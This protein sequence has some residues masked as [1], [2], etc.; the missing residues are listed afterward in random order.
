LPFPFSFVFLKENKGTKDSRCLMKRW[1]VE[2][3]LDF[4]MGFINFFFLFLFNVGGKK[5]MKPIKIQVSFGRHQSFTVSPG[6]WLSI[7][8]AVRPT[9][10]LPGRNVKDSRRPPL[11]FFRCFP[12]GS[13]SS[14]D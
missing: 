5:K 2:K 4:S 9:K 10:V 7:L 6:I 3:K 13:S 11:L 14:S 8:A 1:G 12:F